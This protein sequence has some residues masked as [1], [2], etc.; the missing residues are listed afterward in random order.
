MGINIKYCMSLKNLS[1]Q[2]SIIELPFELKGCPIRV[3]SRIFVVG[4]KG[5]RGELKKRLLSFVSSNESKH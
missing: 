1:K 5:L 3:L 4:G 2:Q